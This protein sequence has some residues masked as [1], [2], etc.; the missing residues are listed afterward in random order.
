[1]CVESLRTGIDFSDTIDLRHHMP[2]FTLKINI[3][4]YISLETP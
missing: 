1:M 4:P 2:R 3:F